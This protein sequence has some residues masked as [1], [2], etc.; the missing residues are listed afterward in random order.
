ML[1][2]LCMALKAAQAEA[3]QAGAL[4]PIPTGVVN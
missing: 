4:K 2:K 3:L 1:S